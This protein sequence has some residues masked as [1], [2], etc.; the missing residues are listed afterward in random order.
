MTNKWLASFCSCSG[1]CF[2]ACCC[3]CILIGKT[4]ARLETGDRDPSCCNSWCVG[5]CV[6]E[7]CG[8]WG[9]ILGMLQRN[10]VRYA[11]NIRGN[12]C[13]DCCASFWCPC[14]GLLQQANE[15]E[16]RRS[17]VIVDRQPQPH[18]GMQM[19]KMDARGGRYGSK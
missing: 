4:Q 8:H 19:N 16:R 12:A 7:M 15:V 1:L 10:H 11:Y 5:Y 9:F 13:C 2:S 18:G 6:L 17:V 14:C 3:P